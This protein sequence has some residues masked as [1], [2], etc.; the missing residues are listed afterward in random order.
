MNTCGFIVPAPRRHTLE[1]TLMSQ[2]FVSFLYVLA[3]HSLIF[4]RFFFSCTHG[5]RTRRYRCCR[6]TR[7]TRT[8]RSRT[9]RLSNYYQII[10][11]VSIN[12]GVSNPASSGWYTR[13]IGSRW[14]IFSIYVDWRVPL[15]LSGRTD[16]DLADV[17]SSFVQI[18]IQVRVIMHLHTR[19][20]LNICG[21]L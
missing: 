2:I 18:R 5:T 3:I 10:R 19:R 4:T 14:H 11:E 16:V 17:Q 6:R 7:P 9:Q 20:N 21:F 13:L 12:L 8:P 1:S 15:R